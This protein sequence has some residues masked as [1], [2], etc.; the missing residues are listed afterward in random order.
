MRTHS[1]LTLLLVPLLAVAAALL[2]VAPPRV[3][4]PDAEF[5]CTTAILADPGDPY[6]VL[7]QEIADREHLSVAA[8]LDDALACDPA[9]L[10]W[11]VSPAGASDAIVTRFLA[12]LESHTRTMATGIITGSTLEN[13]RALYARSSQ[14][15]S[16]R[17]FAIIGDHVYAGHTVELR[18]GQVIT[19]TTATISQTQ[20]ALQVAGYVNYSG[21]G[22]NRSWNLSRAER[23]VSGDIPSLPPLVVSTASCQTARFWQAESI[24]LRFVDQGAAAYSGFYFSPM[25]GYQI[26]EDYGLPLL[27]TWPDFP[28]GVAIQVINRGTRQGYAA[29]PFHLLLGDPRIALRSAPP[30]TVTQDRIEA[31]R[32]VLQLT[33]VPTGI[34]PV[35]ISNGASYHYVDIPGLTAASDSD[36]FYNRRLEMT[37]IGSDKYLLVESR[38]GTLEIRLVREPSLVWTGLDVLTDAFDFALIF[39][40]NAPDGG[41]VLAL[42]LGILVT[43]IVAVGGRCRHLSTR[44][45]LPAAGVGLVCAALHGLYALLRLST[46][47]V[48]IITKP[49]AF[50]LEALPGTMLLCSA[51]AYVYLTR[52]SRRVLLSA[53]FLAPLPCWVASAF[54]WAAALIANLQLAART[55]IETG[56]YG[57]PVALAPLLCGMMVSAAFAW[58]LVAIRTLLG[59][60]RDERLAATPR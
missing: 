24:A 18:A 37:N 31:G 3:R 48:T 2:P 46:E 10:L 16:D 53:A 50:G 5:V 30:Y 36:P 51:A 60:V 4:P 38:G 33:N 7:A 20:Q 14:T 45:V 28:I 42:G 35:R 47:S 17:A 8:T 43:A 34:V 1:T 12:R 27:H 57:S 29:V 13:A 19:H 11:V 39:S 58:L 15:S 55:H 26:G 44:C 41:S 6:H 32:R 25:S 23:L 49:L 9:F 54:L 22:A 21:H 52:P 59:P 56:V 40:N